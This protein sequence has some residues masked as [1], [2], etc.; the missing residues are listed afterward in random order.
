ME[1]TVELTI[2][3]LAILARETLVAVTGSIEAEPV[4]A[5]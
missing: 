3:D 1:R 5:A 4:S 2:F